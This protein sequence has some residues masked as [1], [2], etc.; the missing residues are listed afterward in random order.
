M[1]YGQIEGVNKKISKLV[2]GV[3]NQNDLNEAS[4]LWDHWIDVGGNIF[5]TAYTYGKGNHE[6]V[7]GEWLKQNNIR[8]EIVI[9][10]KGAHTPN[11]NPEAISSQLTESLERM[12]TDYVDIY[13]MHRD[14]DEY[15]VDEFVDVLNQEKDK[16]RI[17]V[18][19]GSNWTLDRFKKAN[20]WAKNNNKNEMSILNNNLALAKMINPLW[21]G[22]LSS[23][24]NDILDYL[25]Q[26]KKSHM[27]WSSQARGYFLDDEITKKIEEKITNDETWRAPGEHSSGPISCYD[28]EDNRERKKRAIELAEKKGCSAHN[29]AASWTINQS[30]PSFALIGPRTINE[31]D[32]TLP[33]LDIELSQEEINWLNLL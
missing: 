16:G 21:S 9:L 10:G 11:C 22:C 2:M 24:D 6:K 20:N 14:N 33:C 32:T 31:L 7:F 19:G 13:I 5:D 28:S 12:N 3:D 29:I 15:N 18:F 4:K 26:T 23:N 8:E 1:K 25:E 27:S 30:F 17:K